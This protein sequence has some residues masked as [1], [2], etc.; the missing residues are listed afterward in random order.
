[1]ATTS[2]LEL[3]L[4]VRA[5]RTY[6]DVFI[7]GQSLC[8]RLDRHEG[9]KVDDVSPVGWADGAVERLL[10]TAPPD[11]PDGRTSLLVCAA[12]ADLSCGAVCAKI[13]RSG[14]LITWSEMAYQNDLEMEPMRQFTRVTGFVFEWSQYRAALTQRG[15]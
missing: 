5:E 9:F 2:T 14:D 6:Y 12:C 11:F 8:E 1:M 13:V 4:T 3:R 10:L 7:N 15:S